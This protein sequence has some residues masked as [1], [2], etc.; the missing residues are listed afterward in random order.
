MRWI[1]PWCGLLALL[2]SAGHGRADGAVTAE[3]LAGLRYLAFVHEPGG[4]PFLRRLPSP[5]VEVVFRVQG[6]F[7]PALLNPMLSVFVRDANYVG[8]SHHLDS[9]M[10]LRGG[11]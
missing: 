3:V 9:E 1:A 5:D 4:E 11:A 6:D 8:A 2:C 7:A 10:Q